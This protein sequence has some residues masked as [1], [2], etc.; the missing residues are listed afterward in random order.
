MRLD[1]HS[2]IFG[3]CLPT[4]VTSVNFAFVVLASAAQ[5]RREMPRAP[6]CPLFPS[7]VPC[8]P[9]CAPVPLTLLRCATGVPVSTGSPALLLSPHTAGPHPLP[10][11]SS[12]H[13]LSCSSSTRPV[14][15]EP[16]RKCRPAELHRATAAAAAV[17]P[18]A[19]GPV[20]ACSCDAAPGV[21]AHS[22]V[23]ADS[24]AA[25]GAQQCDQDKQVCMLQ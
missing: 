21:P 13:Q 25:S 20:V 12:R 10:G 1:S 18:D 9:S 4:T 22:R 16:G 14:R 23:S 8:A 19:A 11:H 5:H 2:V 3:G 7:G 15:A 17:A 24:A 6:S